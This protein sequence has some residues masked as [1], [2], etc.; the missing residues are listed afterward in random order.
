MQLQ[1]LDK[2]TKDNV[3]L[4]QLLKNFENKL[5]QAKEAHKRTL[6]KY[7]VGLSNAS[8]SPFENML[9]SR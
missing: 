7:T 8:A 5:K 1:E 4:K 9:A 3:Q 2:L 6:E